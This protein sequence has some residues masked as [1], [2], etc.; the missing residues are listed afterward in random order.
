MKIHQKSALLSSLGVMERHIRETREDIASVAMDNRYGTS[1]GESVATYAT[2][3]AGYIQERR[4]FC[5]ALN[6]LGYTIEWDGEH[7]VDIKG[8][9]E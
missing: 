3:L 8:E 9:E 6:I 5:Y 7:A 2:R 4:G 1:V